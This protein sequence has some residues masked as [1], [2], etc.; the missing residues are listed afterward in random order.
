MRS[1]MLLNR[2]GL[3]G[4]WARQLVL[5]VCALAVGFGAVP[6]LIFYAGSWALGRYDGASAAG[7]YQ[8]IYHGLPAGSLVSWIV[9][10]GPLLARIGVHFGSMSS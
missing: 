2:L 8:G 3:T 4:W 1:E 5:A 9:V 7:I 10:L 6:L